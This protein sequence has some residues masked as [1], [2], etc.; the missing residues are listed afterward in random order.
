MLGKGDAVG[1]YKLVKFLGRGQFGEVWLAEKKLRLSTRSV[2]HA[3]KFLPSPSDE[4]SIKSVEDEVDTWIEA[5]SHPN[6][7]SVIDMLALDEHIVII[8]DFA[9]GGSLGNWLKS[10]GGKAPT[11]EA[12]L[13]MMIG[14]LRG[15]EHLHARNIVHRDLKP[16]NILLQGNFPRITDF[17]I[18]RIVS[19]GTLKT[20]AIGSPA[21]MSPE[22]FNGSKSPQT[23]IWSAGVILYEMLTGGQPFEDEAL[24]LLMRKIQDEEP[25]PLPEDVKPELRA[26]VEHALQKDVQKR[27]QTA[28]EMRQAVERA[29]HN[30]KSG[31]YEFT[32][33]DIIQK[34][35]LTEKIEISK[36]S[37]EKTIS[38]TDEKTI[39]DF[40][41]SA[42]NSDETVLKFPAED[43]KNI[44]ADKTVKFQNLETDQKTIY[45]LAETENIIQKTQISPVARTDDRQ[46]EKT[47]NWQEA[48]KSKDI[49]LEAELLKLG[50]ELKRN[51]TNN[52]FSEKKGA[53][54]YAG[55]IGGII[56]LIL[57][58]FLIWKFAGNK[59]AEVSNSANANSAN[60]TKT[61]TPTAPDGM[62]YVPGGEFMMGRGDGK[63]EAEMPA[64]KVSVEPFF[65]DIYE[66]SEQ[67]FDD[68]ATKNKG[69]PKVGV[70]WN[71]ADDFCKKEGKRL[72]SEEE[73]EFAARGTNNFLYPWGNDWKQ[74]N[75]NVGGKV[76]AEVGKFKGASPFGNYDMSGNAWEWTSSDFKAY[77]NGKLP[78]AFVGKPN[79]KTIRGGSFEATK[80]FATTTYRI[81]WAATGAVNYDRTGFRCVK[82]IK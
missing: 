73:W 53:G 26:V 23:D 70:N 27:F 66:V 32:S 59:P 82:N 62:V 38:I 46:I 45:P 36:P 55:I 67:K 41:V 21:Y 72:P 37:D 50:D 42:N 71:Q 4:S 56:G 81:G 74:E 44:T 58:G 28:T 17:G 75:A 5:G 10:N 2:N 15:I 78:E 8:S 80:D 3:L 19:G 51:H 9:E 47:A 40:D 64:H 52:S 69:L 16:D 68:P 30:V 63:S 43:S 48:E 20:K 76:F 14:I 77:P 33:G 35:I 7:M 25:K 57:L 24:W 13:E 18:S 11:D 1:D 65:M 31:D 79:L 60:N 29:L 34:N 54:F 39:S 22:A 6:V 12:A 61:E 49:D